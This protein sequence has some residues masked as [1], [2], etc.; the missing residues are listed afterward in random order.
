MHVSRC[1]CFNSLPPSRGRPCRAQ[2]ALIRT[3]ASVCRRGHLG[4][5]GPPCLGAGALD[6]LAHDDHRTQAALGLIIST[7]RRRKQ[8]KKCLCSGPSNRCRT[9]R[10]WHSARGS[11]LAAGPQFST[12]S[13][14]APRRRRCLKQLGCA[15]PPPKPCQIFPATKFSR[16]C[17]SLS[18]V[19]RSC[20]SKSNP[21]LLPQKPGV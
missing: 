1:N 18:I 6:D 3:V 5:V 21:T 7:P 9:S 20:R 12:R 8:L 11:G 10:L 2:W 17:R 4:P 14:M 13:Q 15:L 16:Y 19:A